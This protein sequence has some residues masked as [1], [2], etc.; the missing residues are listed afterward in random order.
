VLH[1]EERP[2]AWQRTR[3]GY[4]QA[5]VGLEITAAAAPPA[6]L[7]SAE[8]RSWFDTSRPGKSA[9]G[10]DFPAVL[11]EREKAAVLEYLKTL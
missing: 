11:D 4:D 3:A 9:A 6:K 8:R 5:R 2:A 10:H 7:P 1:P